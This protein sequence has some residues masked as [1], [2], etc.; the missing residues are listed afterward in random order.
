MEGEALG[1]CVQRG[2][3]RTR[4]RLDQDFRSELRLE[5]LVVDQAEYLPALAGGGDLLEQVFE[6]GFEVARV[7]RLD[8]GRDCRSTRMASSGGEP[9][10]APSFCARSNSQ[11]SALPSTRE[12]VFCR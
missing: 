12:S 7:R 3:V 8:R 11:S 1:D 5:L 2:T 9:A 10:L 4:H 6:V